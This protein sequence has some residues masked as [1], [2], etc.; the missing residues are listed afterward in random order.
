LLSSCRIILVGKTSTASPESPNMSISMPWSPNFWRGQGATGCRC[1][2]QGYW[3]QVLCV[4]LA[5]LRGE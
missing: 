3:S 2:D 4:H 5:L 1:V